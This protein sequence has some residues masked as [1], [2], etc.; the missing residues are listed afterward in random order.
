MSKNPMI[1]IKIGNVWCKIRSCSDSPSAES[2]ILNSSIDMQG[3]MHG[4]RTLTD[5]EGDI[6]TI[7]N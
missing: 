3:M 5:T 1:F 2:A 7:N 6:K 4:L